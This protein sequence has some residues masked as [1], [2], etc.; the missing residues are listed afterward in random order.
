MP[1]DSIS[2]SAKNK[3]SLIRAR[4]RLKEPLI[5]EADLRIEQLTALAIEAGEKVFTDGFIILQ[6]GKYL[7]IGQVLDLMHVMTELQARQ[8]CQLV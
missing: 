4:L 5:V 8:H 2:I 1:G 6:E 7:G 3:S